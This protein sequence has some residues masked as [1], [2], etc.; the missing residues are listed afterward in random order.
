MA[1]VVLPAPFTPTIAIDVPA[2]IVRSKPSSTA[3]RS[4]RYANVTSR[5]RISRAGMPRRRD[6][7]CGATGSA[8]AAAIAARAGSSA[9]TGAAAPSSAQ[10]QPPNAIIDVPT[11]AVRKTM[12]RSRLMWPSA[13]AFAIDHATSAF[14]ASTSDQ[15]EAERA[16]AQPRRLPLELV[17]VAA[18]RGEPLDHPVGEAEQPHFLRGG[19]V[20]REAVRVVG[21][22][23]RGAHLV[24]VAVLPHRALA[25]QVVRRH[26]RADEQRRRP[27]RV[28]EEQQARTRGRR[29][30]RRARSR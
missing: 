11:I 14:A 1:S 25:Q 5:K 26:P 30:S 2:G 17:E 3:G 19:R 22:A 20:D 12:V 8:P 28:A 21:V 6:R 4:G 23:L 7:R 13:A 9:T 10:L 15:A 27:P 18:P 24:G 16:F 29:P